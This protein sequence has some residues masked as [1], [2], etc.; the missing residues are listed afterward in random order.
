MTGFS[1][2]IAVPPKKR[3]QHKITMTGLASEPP[4][5]SA[6]NNFTRRS[7]S[8]RPQRFALPLP[9]SKPKLAGRSVSGEWAKAAQ[10]LGRPTGRALMHF[11][12]HS[13]TTWRRG[14]FP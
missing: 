4:T 5:G 10:R 12:G 3:M 6:E 13:K 14:F 9:L 7:L 8:A 11:N 2:V 1:A